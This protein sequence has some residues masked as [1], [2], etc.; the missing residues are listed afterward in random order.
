MTKHW[1]RAI[2][3]VLYSVNELYMLNIKLLGLSAVGEECK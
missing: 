1:Y 3:R 2:S